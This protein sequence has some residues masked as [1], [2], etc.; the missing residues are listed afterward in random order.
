MQITPPKLRHDHP[1]P[2]HVG[3]KIQE[4]RECKEEKRTNRVERYEKEFLH[5]G[6]CNEICTMLHTR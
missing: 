4:Y 6:Q 2:K 1:A 5:L 3:K